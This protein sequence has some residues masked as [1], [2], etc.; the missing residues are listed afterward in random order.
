MPKWEYNMLE[1][2]VGEDSCIIWEKLDE[3]GREGWELVSVV[4]VHAGN[5]RFRFFF[6]RLL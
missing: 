3:C 6:K 1:M 2:D 5:E 4:V